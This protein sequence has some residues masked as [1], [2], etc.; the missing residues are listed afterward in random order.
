MN[1]LDTF[2]IDVDERLALYAIKTQ[3]TEHYVVTENK[4][5]KILKPLSDPETS[6]ECYYRTKSLDYTDQFPEL[7]NQWTEIDHIDI[8][9]RDIN[10]STPL[11]V[12]LSN[13]DGV[14]WASK[15]TTIGNG[16]KKTKIEP[17]YFKDTAVVFGKLFVV[18]I[19][20]TSSNKNFEL[21]QIRIHIIPRGEYFKVS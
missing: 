12:H 3:L 17:F 14:T 18:K 5:I 15:H 13:D 8:V 9:Y 7:I 16:D 20:S 19:E 21:L 1:Y 11:S 4:I 10:A 6:M 2:I